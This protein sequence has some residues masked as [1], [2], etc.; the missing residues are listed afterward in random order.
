[1]RRLPP[2]RACRLPM[3]DVRAD[4]VAAIALDTTGS[5]VVPVGAGLVPLDE[6][7]LWCDHRSWREAAEITAKAHEYGLEAIGWCGGVYSSE[8]GFSNSFTGYGTIL[9]SAAGWFPAFEHC[10]HGRGRAL[11]HL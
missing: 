4:Q 3:R 10:D 11:R 7:Y 5:S 6:Y 8:W 2:P 1:M 9:T